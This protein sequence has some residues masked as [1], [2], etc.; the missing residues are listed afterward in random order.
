MWRASLSVVEKRNPGAAHVLGRSHEAQ[1]LSKA[2]DAVRR[3]E[4]RALAPVGST[5]IEA[6]LRDRDP[7]VRRQAEAAVED[8][9]WCLGWAPAGREH[10]R[11]RSVCPR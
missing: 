3:D 1:L 6:G 11:G 9:E 7:F 5:G 4:I 10:N 2:V 8:V